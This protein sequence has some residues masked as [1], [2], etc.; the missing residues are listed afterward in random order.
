MAG[1]EEECE[2]CR[3][4]NIPC[5]ILGRGHFIDNI[6]REDKILE[7]KRMCTVVTS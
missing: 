7:K 3:R 4:N 5:N 6:I 1:Y 2:K